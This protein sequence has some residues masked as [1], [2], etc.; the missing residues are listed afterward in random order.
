MARIHSLMIDIVA[1][2]SAFEDADN[3]ELV[4][5]LRSVADR[6]ESRGD[7]PAVLRDV[8]GNKCGTVAVELDD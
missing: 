8:N 1:S 2:G 4:R 7:A 3:S 5:I 6:I